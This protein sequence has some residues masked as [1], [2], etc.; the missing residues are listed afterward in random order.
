MYTILT[1]PLS[2]LYIC[3]AALATALSATA[4]PAVTVA[5]DSA[6]IRI[7]S[8]MHLSLDVSVRA[9]QRVTFA[10]YRPQEELAPGIEVVRTDGP[11]TVGQADGTLHLRHT[12]TLTAF[13]SATYTF[14][15]PPVVVDGDTVAN[16]GNVTLRVVGVAVDTLHLDRFYGAKDVADVPFT[17][18]PLLAVLL[19]AAL[20]FGALAVWALR[21]RR[22]VER[23]IVRTVIEPPPAAHTVALTDLQSLRTRPVADGALPALCD[24]VVAIVRRYLVARFDLDTAEMTSS[25]TLAALRKAG[26]TQALDELQALFRATDLARF[27]GRLAA[28]LTAADAFRPAEAYIQATRDTSPPPPPEVREEPEQLRLYTRRRR[29]WL[30][31]G[32]T[33]VA[34]SLASALSLAAQLLPL[35]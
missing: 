16:A 24:D 25:D 35:L 6:A 27:G 33:A 12:Y 5:Q 7:G 4:Q 15:P 3:I 23:R 11:D 32:L 13:D 28:S 9:G 2:I 30:A 18:R 17:F 14:A 19:A 20:L 31:L 8:Q 22:K 26:H 21:R 10:A 34:A 1:R 29:R